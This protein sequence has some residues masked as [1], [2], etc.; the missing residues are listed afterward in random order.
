MGRIPVDSPMFRDTESAASSDS[1]S[2]TW[3]AIIQQSTSAIQMPEVLLSNLVNCFLAIIC[4][5]SPSTPS[6]EIGS[7]PA[8]SQIRS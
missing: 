5:S 4:T 2:V 7:N 1:G 3:S 6:A 8:I